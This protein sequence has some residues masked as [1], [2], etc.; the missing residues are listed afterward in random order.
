MFRGAFFDDSAFV[1]KDDSVRNFP[2]KAHFVGDD[3]HG[4]VFFRKADHN[5]QNLLNCFR[6]EGR[7]WFIKN[8]DFLLGCKSPCDGNSLLLSAGKGS[9]IDM[10]FIL[11]T[12][13]PEILHGKFFRF[14]F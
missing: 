7:G 9:R 2:G 5:V 1:H 12:D 6:I 8:D 13:E 4:D 14:G 11:K 3:H 10:G